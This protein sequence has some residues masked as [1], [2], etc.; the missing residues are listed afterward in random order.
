MQCLIDD[1]LI[2]EEF[3]ESSNATW[4]NTGIVGVMPKSAVEVLADTIMRFGTGMFYIHQDIGSAIET[5]R[6]RLASLISAENPTDICFTR[7]ATEGITIGIS[8]VDFQPGDEIVTSD[9]EHVY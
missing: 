4:F 6:E 1:D 2:K 8:N 5:L 7:N 3:P 9:Q